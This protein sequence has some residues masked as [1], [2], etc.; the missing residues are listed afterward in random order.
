MYAY[1][2]TR[3]L[4]LHVCTRPLHATHAT[5]HAYA[6]SSLKCQDDGSAQYCLVSFPDWRSQNQIPDNHL[7]C[8]VSIAASIRSFPLTCSSYS[9]KSITIKSTT[10]PV[11]QALDFDV[12]PGSAKS[13]EVYDDLSL[14]VRDTNTSDLM[15]EWFC[16]DGVQPNSCE[17]SSPTLKIA[18]TAWD[19]AACK[20]HSCI[21]N[22]PLNVNVHLDIKTLPI[23]KCPSVSFLGKPCSG[24]LHRNDTLPRGYCG[25]RTLHFGPKAGTPQ[26]TCTCATGY[27]GESCQ[28][29]CPGGIYY[30]GQSGLSQCCNNRGTTSFDTDTGTAVCKCHDHFHGPACDACVAGYYGADC[31]YKCDCEA[32]ETCHSGI[33]S[34]T[35]QCSCNMP[36]A[37]SH[38]T[39]S[40]CGKDHYGAKCF[41]CNCGGFG[42]G[43]VEGHW[44]CNDGRNGTGSCDCVAGWMGE[45]CDQPTGGGGDNKGGQIPVWVA[46]VVAV[47]IVLGGCIGFLI[48][49]NR[50]QKYRQLVERS[51]ESIP[52]NSTE[53]IDYSGNVLSRPLMS[54]RTGN[55][56]QT[57]EN[58]SASISSSTAT[59]NN[60]NSGVIRGSDVTE[61]RQTAGS[62]GMFNMMDLLL[63]SPTKG[64]S[65]ESGRQH[66]TMSRKV[67]MDRL[68]HMSI[69]TD[70]RGSS[71][72][73]ADYTID[74]SLLEMGDK[75]GSGASGE[76]F[77][78]LV[79]SSA[80]KN[81]D[82]ANDDEPIVVAVKK[83]FADTVDKN[84]FQD[85]FRRELQILRR[86]DHPNVVR[87]IGVSVSPDKHYHI[88][89]EL[90]R[91]AL[92]DL[93]DRGKGRLPPS[94]LENITL[95]MI[96]GMQ[97][98][99]V[100]NIVHRDLKPANCLIAGGGASGAL[101]VK[102][103]D[104][105][106]SRLVQHDVTMMTA[107]IGTPAY[108]APEMASEGALDSVEAGK[109]IDV[110]SFAICCL[111]IW[112]QTRPY[113]NKK[114]NAFQLMVKVMR[115]ERPIIP[116]NTLPLKVEMT[117][118][119]CWSQEPTLRPSFA[120]VFDAM[121]NDLA[122][123]QMPTA[124]EIH[125]EE[126]KA[127]GKEDEEEE[128]EDKGEQRVT[129]REVVVQDDNKEI[130]DDDEDEE[131]YGGNIENKDEDE[132]EEGVDDVH[133]LHVVQ[134]VVQVGDDS[135]NER[136]TSAVISGVGHDEV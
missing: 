10:S 37:I 64:S 109:A 22:Y 128:E 50:Q 85:A 32:H 83:L 1:L 120:T 36:F 98:L 96:K 87:L 89:T 29:D 125:E 74:Y 82:G 26:T 6:S 12:P 99:H 42:N 93:L 122:F 19:S 18:T 66:R 8:S 107:E 16:P 111:E 113:R 100:N 77:T 52:I 34:H 132:N 11:R 116:E 90:C 134:H 101:E 35:V 27:V 130:D 91:C 23:T 80:N 112:T 119:K 65:H 126:G 17:M 53:E 13:C 95:Q 21:D 57:D 2:L 63:D 79:R 43:T 5:H 38:G 81:S 67:D 4:V 48:L 20:D 60:N 106:L 105:G 117:I 55:N 70:S 68:L 72:C 15:Q 46:P 118:K 92:N 133:V 76:V 135:D 97:Y 84:Y 69:S 123:F 62:S 56:W 73:D 121:E 102:I 31:K 136:K 114:L 131:I 14:R 104:F 39:C 61:R 24:S 45:G 58:Y 28:A 127:K 49:Y 88:V 103:C 41:Q 115:G 33:N 129:V 78:A 108:M 110:Y 9:L 54:P 124:M 30:P 3:I 44:Q 47:A 51:L 75:I 94:I 71:N 25:C 7:V 59:R 40:E 86:M